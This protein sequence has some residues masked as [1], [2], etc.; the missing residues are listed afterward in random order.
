MLF[1]DTELFFSAESF[2]CCLCILGSFLFYSIFVSVV[3]MSYAGFPVLYQKYLHWFVSEIMNDFITNFVTKTLRKGA[4][5]QEKGEFLKEAQLMSHFHHE[6]ILQLR[7]V[8]LDNDPNFIIM[9]LM[10]GGDLLS[11]LRSSRPLLVSILFHISVLLY[12]S[13]TLPHFPF[14]HTPPTPPH[15]HHF[16][17]TTRHTPP[18]II[19]HHFY[20]TTFF[21]IAPLLRLLTAPLSSYT[22]LHVYTPSLSLFHHSPY[23]NT[24]TPPILLHHSYCPTP[25]TAHSSFTQLLCYTFSYPYT[26]PY[27]Y[28]LPHSSYTLSHSSYTLSLSYSL[29]HSS[30]SLLAAKIPPL[31]AQAAKL[32]FHLLR[33]PETSLCRN[34]LTVTSNSLNMALFCTIQNS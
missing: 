26:F 2:V 17:Y 25:L 11:F 22:F 34:M 23:S 18:L 30:T 13:F 3:F 10:E 5:E 8:C 33:T 15:L 27:S 31:A 7:G 4:T 16:Y 14:F 20:S 1:L 29:L 28:T 32:L 6:H 19:L 21:S 24:P 12:S 9:E